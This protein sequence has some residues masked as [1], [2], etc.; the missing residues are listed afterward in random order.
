MYKMKGGL[1]LTITYLVA[2][3]LIP[4]SDSVTVFSEVKNHPCDNYY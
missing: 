2:D 4:T 1:A 3:G